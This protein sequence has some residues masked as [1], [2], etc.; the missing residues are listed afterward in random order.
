MP[1]SRGSRRA[2]TGSITLAQLLAA[3]L[4]HN[5]IAR[6]VTDGRLHRLY[7]GVYAVGHAGLSYEGRV[8]A[9]V[10]ACGDGAAA[11]R[12]TVRV[13][14]RRLTVPPPLYRCCRCP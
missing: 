4:S 12:L 3:G 7:H 5:A 8:L 13:P 10:F 1:A 6:R 11:G 9:S 2:S 14:A